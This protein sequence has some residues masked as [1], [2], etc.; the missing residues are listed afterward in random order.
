MEYKDY[1]IVFLVIILA[2]VLVKPDLRGGS[3]NQEQ[4]LIKTKNIQYEQLLNQKRDME[5]ERDSFKEKLKHTQEK[6]EKCTQQFNKLIK[7]RKKLSKD[8]ESAERDLER[9]LEY[10]DRC[11][12]GID[13]CQAELNGYGQLA[14]V[15]VNLLGG[16]LSLRG[17]ISNPLSSYRSQLQSQKRKELSFGMEKK[18][19]S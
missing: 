2:V 6:L 3:C 16:Y 18:K 13:E 15:N 17:S 9:A 8:K 5:L 19:N 4:D 14:A 12:L 10:L 7:E 1:I 11:D